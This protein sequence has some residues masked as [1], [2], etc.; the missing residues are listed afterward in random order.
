MANKPT[1]QIAVHGNSIEEYKMLVTFLKEKGYKLIG[2]LASLSDDD[3]VKA[4][5][6]D[7]DK[8]TAHEPSTTIMACYVTCKKKIL[9]VEEYIAGEAK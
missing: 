5:M 2:S 6:I 4:V 3:H 1:G 9:S 7:N 8:K